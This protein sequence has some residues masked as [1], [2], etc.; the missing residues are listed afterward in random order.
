MDN[1]AG[2][3]RE[4]EQNF[5]LDEQ[6]LRKIVDLT[7]EQAK[8]LPYE[9][10]I[11]FY[12]EQGEN[13]F[14]HTQKIEDIL[15]DDNTREKSFCTVGIRLYRSESDSKTDQKVTGEPNPIVTIGFTSQRTPNVRLTVSCD[16]RDWTFLVFDEL[17]TQIKRT[18]TKK[19]SKIFTPSFYDILVAAIILVVG[20]SLSNWFSQKYLPVIPLF[21]ISSM[22]IDEKLSK[23]LELS[24]ARNNSPLYPSVLPLI[25]SWIITSIIAVVRPFKKLVNKFSKSYFLWGDMVNVFNRS[26]SLMRNIKWIVI[27][28]LF[29]TIVGGI[30]VAL[31][32][33]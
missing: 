22:T 10:H 14:Y 19:A 16:N 28:G 25:F 26:E 8:K 15:L 3:Y 1:R 21:D 20:L 23:L 29:V 9:T 6:K 30:I 7:K 4:Y 13:T 2:I 27:V 18:L 12:I 33:S 11:E 17:D 32:I 31:I 24:V 5:L